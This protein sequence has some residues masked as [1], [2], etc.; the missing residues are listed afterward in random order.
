MTEKENN[1]FIPVGKLKF[2]PLKFYLIFTVNIIFGV[3]MVIFLILT[4][5]KLLYTFLFVLFYFPVFVL[6]LLF[7]I[8]R[9]VIDQKRI[10]SAIVKKVAKN[11]IIAKFFTK[12]KRLEEYAIMLD[13]NSKS[14]KY[15]GGLYTIDLD[16]V[17]PNID[18]RPCS[19]YVKGIPNP[20]KFNFE[21]YIEEYET[22][23]K[24]NEQTKD[25][26]GKLIEVAYSSETLIDMSK[27]KFFHELHTSNTSGDIA[28]YII[29]ITALFIVAIVIIIIFLGK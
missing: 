12:N 29:I 24:N 16:C 22:N 5:T 21:K 18:N 28:K 7:I 27:D 9:F 4:K 8:I 15:A 1:I 3:L 6:S 14:F 23:F 17:F 20:L 2:K 13:K 25:W 11:F 19:F 10:K 26:E